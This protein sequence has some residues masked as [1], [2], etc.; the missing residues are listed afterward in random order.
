MEARDK[1]A[2]LLI[3]KDLQELM[4]ISDRLAVIYSGSIVRMIDDPR[5]TDALR[6]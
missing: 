1:G 4:S 3:S 5:S 6:P 2:V